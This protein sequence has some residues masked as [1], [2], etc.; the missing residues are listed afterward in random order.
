MPVTR[1]VA[2]AVSAAW[3]LSPS[4]DHVALERGGRRLERLVELRLESPRLRRLGFPAHRRAQRPMRHRLVGDRDVADVAP[5]RDGL[6]RTQRDRRAQRR[7]SLRRR[8]HPGA[9]ALQPRE[10]PGRDRGDPH[11]DL[12]AIRGRDVDARLEP[13]QRS[14]RGLVGATAQRH[15]EPAVELALGRGQRALD[16]LQRRDLLRRLGVERRLRRLR[17]AGRTREH[18]CRCPRRH[19]PAA[20]HTDPLHRQLAASYPSMARAATNL[21]SEQHVQ[22]TGA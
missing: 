8:A 4:D 15:H 9:Y 1:V 18:A 21:N 6:E 5:A 17:G 19:C 22:V 13:W 16:V 12:R 3:A 7:L 20:T 14:R 2:R 11:V 10:Q